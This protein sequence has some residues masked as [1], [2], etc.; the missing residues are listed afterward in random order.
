MPEFGAHT[1]AVKGA[2]CSIREMLFA[3]WAVVL[4]RARKRR[5]GGSIEIGDRMPIPSRR[6]SEER[7]MAIGEVKMR[8]RLA[9]AAARS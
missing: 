8:A 1:G 7:H 2:G 9:F 6:S 4:D 3:S 5:S